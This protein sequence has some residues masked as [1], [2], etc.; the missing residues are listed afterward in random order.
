MEEI[1]DQVSKCQ[2]PSSVINSSGQTQQL[3]DVVGCLTAV[4]KRSSFLP[5]GGI[6][7]NGTVDLVMVDKV[8]NLIT[9]I[10]NKV[11]KLEKGDSSQGVYYRGVSFQN[12]KNARSWVGNG[13]EPCVIDHIIDPHMVMEYVYAS[14]VG[15]DILKTFENLN[16]LHIETLSQGLMMTNY[17]QVVPKLF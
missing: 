4:E 14:L 9:S 10:G 7:F 11:L 15:E 13:V 6:L 5:F 8:R 2:S 1:Y 3:L 17:Q 12:A 16:G